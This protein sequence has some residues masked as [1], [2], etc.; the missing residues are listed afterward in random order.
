[1][2]A[3]GER[4]A[5]DGRQ[6]QR[7]FGA[8]S[9]VGLSEL[10]GG[11]SGS[12]YLNLERGLPAG[13]HLPQGPSQVPLCSGSGLRWGPSPAAGQAH[14]VRRSAHL[15]GGFRPLPGGRGPGGAPRHA[16]RARAAGHRRSQR[17][18]RCRRGGVCGGVCDRAASSPPLRA[19]QLADVPGHGA[20]RRAA[21]V[22][23]R[24]SVHVGSPEQLRVL[25]LCAH[26][27]LPRP[28][29]C[30]LQEFQT[31]LVASPSNY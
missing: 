22:P 1:M 29:P 27:H 25:W 4:E 9:C 17:W 5:R 10:C 12:P 13:A 26:S 30:S 11:Y 6:G 19:E 15:C 8:L 28:Y 23:E 24:L 20:A 31:T 21:H 14:A 2:E 7:R 3:E 16:G 18:E